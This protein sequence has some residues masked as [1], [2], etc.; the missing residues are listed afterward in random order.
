MIITAEMRCF[1]FL[2]L[3]FNIVFLI[4]ADTLPL[5][6]TDCLKYLEG[7]TLLKGYYI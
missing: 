7:L 4:S 3:K 2:L 6:I 1:T 5:T